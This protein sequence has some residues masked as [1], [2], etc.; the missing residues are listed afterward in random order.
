MSFARFLLLGLGVWQ[1]E[2]VLGEAA[3]RNKKYSEAE[4]YS[5]LVG[6]P[7]LLIGGPYGTS[8]LRHLFNL[9]AHGCGDQCLDI[10]A[11]ACKGCPTV[12]ADI[13]DI[14]FEDGYFGSVLASHVVEHLST[15]DDGVKAIQEMQR[16]GDKVW[17]AYPNKQNIIAQLH[18][19]HHLWVWEEANGFHLEQRGV[20]KDA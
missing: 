13:R 9:R 15:V 2:V 12:V 11:I 20:V 4:A 19:G 6:K 14:P 16:V 8:G 18:K 10:N 3:D 7:F 5:K 1:G 17:I